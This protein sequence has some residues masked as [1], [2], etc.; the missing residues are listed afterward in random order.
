[1]GETSPLTNNMDKF[2]ILPLNSPN[3]TNLSDILSNA[4]K[5]FTSI[6]IMVVISVCFLFFACVA[7]IVGLILLQMGI[8]AWF[9]IRHNINYLFIKYL[10]VNFWI[11]L[12]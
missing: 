1:M 8:D 12:L 10:S 7:Y 4:D 2:I 3:I 6:Q 11:S 9:N 5:N